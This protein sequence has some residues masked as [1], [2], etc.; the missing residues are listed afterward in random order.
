M[1]ADS[2]A[3]RHQLLGVDNNLVLL[4]QQMGHTELALKA[5]RRGVEIGQRLVELAPNV[6]SYG[7]QLA[8]HHFALGSPLHGAAGRNEQALRAFQETDHLLSPVLQKDPAHFD[9]RNQQIQSRYFCCM[10]LHG[11][12]RL[13]EAVDACRQAHRLTEQLHRD[14]SSNPEVADFLARVCFWL[15]KVSGKTGQKEEVIAALKQGAEVTGR[16]AR[17]APNEPRWRFR[18]GTLLHCLASMFQDMHRIAEAADYFRRAAVLRESACQDAPNSL[19]YHADTGGTWH[20]LGELEER[21]GHAEEALKAYQRAIESLRAAANFPNP[22]AHQSRLR[23]FLQDEARLT[24]K[25]GRNKEC[26]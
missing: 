7:F 16:L 10:C 25:L 20:R 5:H 24:K 1:R 12:G 21:L 8:G 14:Q 19:T 13:K 11:L 23:Q 6:P 2:V 26:H 4:E 17:Q 18:Q 22:T 3:V 9:A 15:A